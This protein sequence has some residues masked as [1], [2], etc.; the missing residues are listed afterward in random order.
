MEWEQAGQRSSMYIQQQVRAVSV[1]G[2]LV[3]TCVELLDETRVD[4]RKMLGYRKVI[5]ASAITGAN[6]GLSWCERPR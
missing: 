1:R 4:K 5:L 6:P 2:D 3:W